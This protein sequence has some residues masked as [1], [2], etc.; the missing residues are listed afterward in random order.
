MGVH[1]RRMTVILGPLPPRR[2]SLARR[3]APRAAEHTID[4]LIRELNR[5]STTRAQRLA[6]HVIGKWQLTVV[7]GCRFP[8]H[9]QHRDTG[10]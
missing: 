5:M 6:S 9:G 1:P 7:M 4:S 10:A 3:H 2:H 8:R